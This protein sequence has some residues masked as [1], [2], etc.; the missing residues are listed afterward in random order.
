MSDDEVQLNKAIKAGRIPIGI[1]N[2]N[3]PCKS[4]SGIKFLV[5]NPFEIEQIFYEN[6]VR[7]YKG[8]P[9]HILETT[10]LSI[11]ELGIGD[12]ENLYKLYENIDDK[13]SN[14]QEISIKYKYHRV[15]NNQ[16]ARIDYTNDKV[17]SNQEARIEY[18]NDK[19]SSNQEARIDYTN[20]KVSSN[21]EARIEYI[22][23][24]DI[25]NQ[26]TN[27]QNELENNKVVK[28]VLD[29][30]DLLE[31]GFLCN[32]E[33]QEEMLKAYIDTMYKIYGYGMWGVEDKKTKEM[34]AL[35]GFSICRYKEKQYLQ[36]S[37]GVRYDV[38][39]KGYASEMVT[40]ILKYA[41]DDLKFEDILCI[42]KRDNIA[43][44]A[45]ANKLGF[46]VI[47]E[48]QDKIYYRVIGKS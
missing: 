41:K 7:R 42:I 39:R 24:K 11:R 31:D 16:E 14:N 12:V 19:V 30:D 6:V 32:I 22:N 25:N 23:D 4:F 29:I 48:S 3:L 36:L 40:E 27:R 34:V 15:S 1:I 5:E 46:D 43:S 37:Y 13:T 18:T 38:R 17:S 44:I 21:Q 8:Y 47:E 26:D 45:V 20:D 28:A 9:L 33:E 35:V 10:R 2:P